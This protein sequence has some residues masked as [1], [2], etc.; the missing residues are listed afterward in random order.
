[1]IIRDYELTALLRAFYVVIQEDNWYGDVD[2][3]K[4]HHLVREN[5]PLKFQIKFGVSTYISPEDTVPVIESIRKIAEVVNKL[6]KAKLI[7]RFRDN[8][9]NITFASHEK[10]IKQYIKSI[11][12]GEIPAF[13]NTI[14]NEM[15]DSN[16][17]TD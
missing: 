8:N 7:F 12:K 10:L 3:E 1:M 13:I 15:A 4:K 16:T 2:V 17:I 11:R 6:N 5:S 9:S 14:E